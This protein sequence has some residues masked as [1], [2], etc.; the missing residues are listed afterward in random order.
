MKAKISIPLAEQEMHINYCP[1][2]M[3]KNCEIYTTIPWLMK[4]LE[5]LVNDNPDTCS[6]VTDDQYSYTVSIPYKFI[7]PRRPRQMTQEQ[8]DVATQRLA[9]L[10]ARGD[11]D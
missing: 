11:H 3:G 4:N 5:K 8:I 1:Y 9:E 7:K 2:E 6:V 10:R